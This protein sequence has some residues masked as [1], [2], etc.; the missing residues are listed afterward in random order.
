MIDAGSNG[1]EGSAVA[2]DHTQAF[3]AAFGIREAR[4]FWDKA[5]RELAR[6]DTAENADIKVD[7]MLNFARSLIALELSKNQC[8]WSDERRKS[9][10]S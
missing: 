5:G 2:Y 10:P 3:Q 8:G 6:C 4:W 7:C 9:C 1:G